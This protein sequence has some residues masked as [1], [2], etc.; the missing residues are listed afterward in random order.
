MPNQPTKVVMLPVGTQENLNQ[1]VVR[2]RIPASVVNTIFTTP[3]DIVIAV[4][5][6]TLLPQTMVIRKASGAYTLGAATFLDV[7]W[8]AGGGA[9]MRATLT[10]FLDQA[11]AKVE[12]DLGPGPGS[13]LYGTLGATNTGNGS[14]LQLSLAGGN[15]SGAGGELD[16]TLTYLL[17]RTQP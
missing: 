12:L 6:Y 14:S 8:S 3:L 5:G 4:T 10:S 7:K 17:V 13:G 2:L 16:L 15:T 9:L 1:K 11:A